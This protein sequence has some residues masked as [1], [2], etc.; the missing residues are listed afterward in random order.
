MLNKKT[1]DFTNIRRV[2]KDVI[3]ASKNNKYGILDDNLAWVLEPTYK[4]ILKSRN[5]DLLIKEKKYGLLTNKG[6][7]LIAPLLKKKHVQPLK[8]GARIYST[9]AMNGK[10]N[11]IHYQYGELFKPFS[12]VVFEANEMVIKIE[13]GQPTYY[14]NGIELNTNKLLKYITLFEN[15]TH[16]IS[17]K[18]KKIKITDK[19]N[20]TSVK[21]KDLIPIDFHKYGITY[22]KNNTQ[23]IINY[24]GSVIVEASNY[25][26]YTELNENLLI[27]TSVEKKI[28]AYPL[29]SP[30]E[31]HL[32]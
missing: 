32:L 15:A 9:R 14:K 6:E 7:Q 29:V 22:F 8:N 28:Y 11:Y 12:G 20:E 3:I 26:S 23:G 16:I 30:K 31:S 1:T 27:T 19:R 25:L 2:S 18:R 24:T 5:N 10:M 21:I 4:R 13:H 17:K